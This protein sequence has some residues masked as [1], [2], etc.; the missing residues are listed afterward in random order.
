MEIKASLNYLRIAPRKVR[1][2]ADLIRGMEV[3]KA[4]SILKFTE[5]RAAEPLLKLLNSGVANAKKNFNLT[6][7]QIQKLY[8]KEIN[9]D[10]GPKLKRWIP[11]SRGT[12][13]E[14]QKKTSHINLVLDIKEENSKSKNL[15]SKQ[16]IKKSQKVENLKV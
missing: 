6:E 4:Q 5:K 10:E 7:E 16:Q 11:V 13:H 14:I 9:V 8:I 2:V 15:N 3:N 1:L 12:A